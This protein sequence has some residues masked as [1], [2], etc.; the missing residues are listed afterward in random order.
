MVDI[1]QGFVPLATAAQDQTL[2]DKV[3]QSKFGPGDGKEAVQSPDLRERRSGP[4]RRETFQSRRSS[5]RNGK[6]LRG[7]K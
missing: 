3:T 2:Y 5:V 4:V 6:T 7:T 1:P